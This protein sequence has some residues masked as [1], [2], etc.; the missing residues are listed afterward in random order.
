MSTNT[1]KSA[2]EAA[3]RAKAKPPPG[4]HDIDTIATEIGHNESRTADILRELIKAGR[5][6]AIAGK[7]IN[8][9]GMLIP[10]RYFRLIQQA[11]P[12]KPA[13]TR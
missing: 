1:W 11:S 13:M 10:C 8:A 9:M 2:A 5:A 7:K 4:F 3:R 6:E 12:K